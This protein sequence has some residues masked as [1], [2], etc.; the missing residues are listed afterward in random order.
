MPV[1][2]LS[3]VLHSWFWDPVILLGLGLIAASYGYGFYYFRRN[4]WLERVARRGLI[5]RSQPLFF[6]AGLL[7]LF[8]ALVSPVHELSEQLL[9]GHMLQHILLMFVA[10]VLLLLGM[11]V[12]FARL[13]I[14]QL[15][16]RPILAWLVA[17]TVA[18]ALYNANLLV[19]HIPILYDAAVEHELVHRLE[20]AL[21][22]LTGLIAWWP[23]VDPTGG[24]FRAS[25]P[26]R[27]L[28][29][30]LM[31]V[32]GTGLAAFLIYSTRVL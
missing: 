8:I 1:T 20:H 24:W 32:P 15:K 16:L 9:T 26:V 12:P 4:G 2:A 25:G 21:F 31:M 6:A 11:P 10:P 22:V 13:A 29:L 28:Y 30:F 5:R 3:F 17:P 7:T 23:V 14:S 18:Y 19:W 27:L